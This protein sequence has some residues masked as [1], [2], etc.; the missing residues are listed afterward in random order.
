MQF[1]SYNVENKTIQRFDYPM[2][3]KY[4]T[5]NTKILYI[6]KY[7]WALFVIVLVWYI[8]SLFFNE[9]ILPSPF[10]VFGYFFQML[11]TKIFWE[12]A[13][14]SSWRVASAL[15]LAFCIAFPLGLYM[16]YKRKFDAYVS[17]IVFLTY[18]IPKIVFLPIF[19]M[20]FG[21]NDFPRILLIALTV[22]YPILV[23]TRSAIMGLDKKYFD[24]FRSLLPPMHHLQN[25]D[26]LKKE[27]HQKARR[28]RKAKLFHL[29]IPAALPD[30]IM[31]LKVAS[32]TSIAVLF[33]VESF[34]NQKGFGFLIMDAFGR[35]DTLI[36]FSGII[37]MSL[38]GI[39]L[40]EFC[41]MLERKFCAWK[42]KK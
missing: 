35:S 31:S 19:L 40:Y 33:M 32:G 11:K 15:I 26:I 3:L 21:L 17:P 13:A 25:S 2:L 34:A 9:Y 37:S 28:Y 16:G 22:A 36:M 27:K 18:P 29:L 38:M 20:L 14:A 1:I 5:N 7:V 23:V 42:I 30:A 12:H 41:N 8:T 4:F 39:L 6:L 24:S 10:D